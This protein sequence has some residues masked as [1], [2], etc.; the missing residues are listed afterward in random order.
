M[1][2]SGLIWTKNPESAAINPVG[3]AV[4]DHC[5]CHVMHL[6]QGSRKVFH[7]G[8][9]TSMVFE[10]PTDC[11]TRERK[12]ITLSQLQIPLSSANRKGRCKT[13]LLATKQKLSHLSKQ[14]IFPLYQNAHWR[15]ISQ[16]WHLEGHPLSP[17]TWGSALD[18]PS[19][20]TFSG[21]PFRHS[22]GCIALMFYFIE[23]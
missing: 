5:K 22:Y 8:T 16:P 4:N 18:W 14:V 6:L 12:V 23:S 13:Y 20:G 3:S 2:S 7:H 17:K 1:L 21:M 10:V 15:N 11:L 9:T 19:H